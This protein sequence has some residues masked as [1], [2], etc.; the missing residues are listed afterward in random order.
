MPRVVVAGAGL[1]GLSAARHLSEADWEV[2]VLEARREVGG[3]VRSTTLPNGEIAELGAE[4]IDG[5][6]ETVRALAGRL[7]VSLIPAG[8]DF[9]RREVAVGVPVTLAEQGR[10][11]VIAAEALSRIGAAERARS[12]AGAFV[13]GLPIG[14][15]QR[16]FL[17]ARLQGSYGADLDGVALRSLAGYFVTGTPGIYLRSARGNQA[18]AEALAARLGDVRFEHQV[19]AVEHGGRGATVRCVVRGEALAIPAEFAVLALPAPLLAKVEFRPA[20]P[21]AVARAVARLPMGVASKL[22]VTAKAPPP[23]RAVQD[24]S[25]PYWCWSGLGDSGVPRAAITA[26]AGSPQ[27]QQALGTESGDPRPWLLRVRAA[28]PDAVIADDG[29]LLNWGLEPWARGCYSAFDNPSWDAAALLSRPIG[30]LFFAGEH[31]AGADFGTMEGALKSGLRAAR[32]LLAASAKH[33]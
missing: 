19:T 1:A 31:T 16:A 17:R 2:T 11:E 24:V 30:R 7:G 3:R 12:T 14:E 15:A 20:L 21:D 26:F 27:A 8:V 18:L 6:D 4:W 5:R 29:I 22:A 33:P 10:L 28:R 25:V 32:D 23:L 13:A 9:M